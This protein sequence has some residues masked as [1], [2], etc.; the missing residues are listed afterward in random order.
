MAK[1]PWKSPSVPWQACT[2]EQKQMLEAL[3]RACDLSWKLTPSQRDSFKKIMR[4]MKRSQG[5]ERYAL[6]ISR[7]WG[8]SVLLCLLA[9]MFAMGHQG[10]RI[11]YIAPTHDMVR[12]I[13]VPLMDL[14]LQD[15]PPGLGPTW[16]KSEGTYYFPNGSRIEL[17]GLDVRPDGARGTGV[18]L[19][20]LDEAGFFTN[21][22]YLVNSVV[23]PQMLGRAH[24]RIIAASTPPVTPSH[25]WSESFVP[26]CIKADAHDIKTLDDADQYTDEEIARFYAQMPGGRNGIAARREYRAQHIADDTMM[27]IPEF[28]DAAEDREEN[29]VQVW[30][31]IVREHD[32]PTW[33]DCY[34]AL[35]PGWTDMSGVLFG[36]LDFGEQKLVVEDELAE[37]R[38]NSADI[39][40]AIRA[41]EDKL[42]GKLKRRGGGSGFDGLKP[43]PF[44]RISDNNDPRLLY[45]LANDHGLT[46]IATEK[47][48]LIQAV[49]ALRQSVQTGKL[50][51]NPRCRKLIKTLRNAV[52]RKKPEM[53]FGGKMVNG[54]F[55]DG[56]QELGHF[57][58]LAALI[59]M[60]RNVQWRR[61]PTPRMEGYLHGRQ[62]PN[63]ASPRVA[64][65]P[66]SS[67]WLRKGNRYFI[68]TGKT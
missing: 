6:D 24:A 5:G 60:H 59:Y 17:I 13:V 3:W 12:K 42:W 47:D 64:E 22:E 51:I 35:D 36:Y 7:R 46:F 16:N 32:R 18:D 15:C 1:Q 41:K 61:N 54:S 34:T 50:I 48:N 29:G 9:I 31:G 10:W 11:V 68:K 4:W 20:L 28:Q 30:R 19:V 27:I 38:L 45:D 14:L 2:V 49:D 56:G 57:D 55:G 66:N 37:S 58:L 67:K 21:L 62:N 40:R 25:Y 44:L 23:G 26:Q 52:W 43:Q 39:A 65:D 63:M 8:K 53:G 33:I